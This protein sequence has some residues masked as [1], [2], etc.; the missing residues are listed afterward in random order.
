MRRSCIAVGE[1]RCDGCEHIIRHPEH[2]LA[3][4][5]EEDV[6]AQWGKTSRYC[7][8]CSLRKGYAHYEEAEKGKQIVVFFP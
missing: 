8:E 2:Y 7:I 4:D 3:I 5:E 1:I 6:E